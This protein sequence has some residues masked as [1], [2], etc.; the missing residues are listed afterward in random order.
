MIAEIPGSEFPEEIIT[1][2]RHI[3]SSNLGHGAMDYAG[4]SLLAGKRQEF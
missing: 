4:A 1:V 3:D 2:G